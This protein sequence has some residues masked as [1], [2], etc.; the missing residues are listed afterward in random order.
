MNISTWGRRD[1]ERENLTEQG[2]DA[3]TP[4]V[5]R[6]ANHERR[7]SSRDGMPVGKAKNERLIDGE[8]GLN[9][10]RRDDTVVESLWGVR[11]LATSIS[12]SMGNNLRAIF[13]SEAII[14]F[15]LYV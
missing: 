13:D 5:Y 3:I 12:D 10:R 9:E 14:H 1:R 8:P 4:A 15:L 7:A 2:S 6:V 11:I